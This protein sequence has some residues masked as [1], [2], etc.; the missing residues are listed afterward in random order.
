M[1]GAKHSECAGRYIKC[2]LNLQELALLIYFDVKVNHQ[3]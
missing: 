3:E 1:I 2:I